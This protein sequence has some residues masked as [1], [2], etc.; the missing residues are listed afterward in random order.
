VLA[1]AL[2]QPLW[3]VLYAGRR[4]WTVLAVNA[5]QTTIRL[6]A[7]VALIYPLGYNGLAL[8]AALGLSIQLVVLAWLVRRHLGA[9]LNRDWWQSALYGIL[10]TIPAL[11]AAGFLV[12]QLSARPALVALL[13]AGTTGALAYLVALWLLERR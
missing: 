3:R 11:I 4:G 5:L 10:A 2:C 13:I 1:D 7:N 6:L 8:S 9:Y 12:R